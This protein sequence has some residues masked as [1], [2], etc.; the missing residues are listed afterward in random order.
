MPF[1]GDVGFPRTV[2]PGDTALPFL[3]RAATAGL[4]F[5]LSCCFHP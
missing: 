5:Y 1:N 2:R 4:V 3:V